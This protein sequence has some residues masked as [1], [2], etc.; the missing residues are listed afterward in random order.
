MV[1]EIAKLALLILGIIALQRFG[2]RVASGAVGAA[3]GLTAIAGVIL[4]MREGPSPRRLL[5]GFLQPLAAC[6]VMAAAVYGARD[7]L[8]AMGWTH[9]AV[10]LVAL[11]V[12][13]AAV[14]VGAALV[15]CRETSRDLLD[16]VKK[17]LSR[18]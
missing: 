2:I 6:A 15:I 10:M 5:A 9:P 12:S 1:L 7:V 8:V 4:V 3:F 13:G 17:A 11:I 16:L 14:Y 18:S